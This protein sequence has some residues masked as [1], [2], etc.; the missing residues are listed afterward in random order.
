MFES[1]DHAV[2]R[3]QKQRYFESGEHS[4]VHLRLYRPGT[5]YRYRM[6]QLA[7]RQHASVLA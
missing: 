5:R 2:V 6:E 4:D 1:Q 3:P 7:Q